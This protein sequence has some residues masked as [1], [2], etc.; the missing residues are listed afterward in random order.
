MNDGL[1]MNQYLNTIKG[2]REKPMGLDDLQSLVHK[3]CRVYGYFLSHLP[4][5]VL[6][7][8]LG[9]YLSQLCLCIV[10]KGTSGGSEQEPVRSARFPL[11]TLPDGAVFAIDRQ[12]LSVVHAG[13]TDYDLAGHHQHFFAGQGNCLARPQSC[14]SRAQPRPARSGYDNEVNIGMAGYF[15]C[16]QQLPAVVNAGLDCRPK[17]LGLEFPDLSFQQPE[18]LVPGQSYYLCFVRQGTYYIQ[19]LPSYRTR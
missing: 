11:Q 4:D 14:Q 6:E 15:F 13:F 5:G 17:H 2:E 9:R 18:V 16:G 10:I 7:S 8:L 12:N 1:G 3:R 19:G